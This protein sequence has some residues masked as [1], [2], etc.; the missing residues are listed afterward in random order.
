MALSCGD[1]CGL[2]PLPAMR[3]VHHAQ[4][5]NVAQP[6]RR[7]MEFALAAELLDGLNQSA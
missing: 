4:S 2:S 7:S 3:R 6:H 1:I 5:M